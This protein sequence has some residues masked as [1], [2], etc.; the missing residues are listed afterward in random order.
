M[1]GADSFQEILAA[2]IRPA[3]LLELALLAV[4]LGLAWLVSAW[5]RPRHPAPIPGGEGVALAQSRQ[6][7]IWFGRRGFDGA[8]FP[9]LA[10]ALALLARWL[11]RGHLPLAVF[12]LAVPVLLSLA[13]IRVSV[14]VLHAA[15]P[16]SALVRVL[17]RTLSWGV[18]IAAVLWTTGALPVML[19]EMEAISW[20]IG[21]APVSLRSLVEGALSAVAVLLLM[22]W[23]SATI[24]A[25]LLRADS[26]H[27]SVRKIAANATRALL[28]LV[29]LLVALSAAGIPLGALGVMGG[30]VGVGIGLGL[31]RL[32]ANYVSGFVILAERSLRIGDLVRVDNFEGRISDITTRYTLIKA[33]NGRESIVP[34]ELLVTQ[35]VENLSFADNNLVLTT[36]VQVA[37]GTDLDLLMP[38]LVAAVQQV[39]RVLPEPGPSVRLSAFAD[40]GLELTVAFWIGDPVN[41]QVNAIGAVN[42]AIL[43]LLNAEGVEIPFPQRVV[44]GLPAPAPAAVDATSSHG[45][46]NPGNA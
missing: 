45:D 13:L 10:L 25:R 41:G 30:A 2:L 23:L 26:M 43:R 18:W 22:L 27:L 35:R 6:G 4:C 36:T 40:S 34:N 5:L 8:L 38:R 44:H 32:A 9:I 28:L 14:R 16:S 46:R 12:Q 24:E 3:A 1:N 29:G 11:L 15:F 7:G 33:P 31:Q 17:E 20:K 21:G 42:L 39:P 19:T 37:Y